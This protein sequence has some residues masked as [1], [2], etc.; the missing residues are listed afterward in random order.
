M[1]TSSTIIGVVLLALFII[2]I[3]LIS[4]SSRKKRNRLNDEILE[5]AQKHDLKISDSNTWNE[6]ALAIDEE[7][8][9]IIFIDETHGEKEV[10][11]FGTKELRSFRT[12]PDIHKDKS[13]DLRKEARLGLSFLFKES[14]KPEI[15][16]TFYIAGFGELSKHEKQLFEKWSEKIRNRI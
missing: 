14:S 1:N 5:I 2:P 16:I 8:N 11:I 10:K 9:K 3:V 7:K 4:R 15:N 13:I 6:S 12:I